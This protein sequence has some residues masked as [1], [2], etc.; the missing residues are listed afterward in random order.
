MKISSWVTFPLGI[1]LGVFIIPFMV[2]AI[3]GHPLPCMM[4][5]YDSPSFLAK[6]TEFVFPMAQACGGG[7][8]GG[9][10]QPP[11]VP[12]CPLPPPGFKMEDPEILSGAT[13]RGACGTNC[14]SPSC[15]GSSVNY[16]YC[17][18]TS[19]A[20][21]WCSYPYLMCG[22][23]PFCVKHDNC[24]DH[25]VVR[26]E[27]CYAACNAECAIDYPTRPDWCASWLMG[28]GPYTDTLKYVNFAVVGEVQS[29]P[30][31]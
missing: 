7:R 28:G 6:V 23:H 1:V 2:L 10:V 4:P 3:D 26:D 12:D 8:S 19:S 24:Y 16:E 14:T 22:S 20:H 18:G 11:A 13:C 30:C 25:C 9:S 17:I 29:G 31:P 27:T 21:R 15:V 5:V